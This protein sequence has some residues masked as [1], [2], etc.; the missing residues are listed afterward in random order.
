MEADF[1]LCLF[2]YPVW[3]AACLAGRSVYCQGRTRPDIGEQRARSFRNKTGKRESHS[4]GI[5]FY[6]FTFFWPVSIWVF[7]YWVSLLGVISVPHLFLEHWFCPLNTHTRLACSLAPCTAGL[8]YT[9]GQIAWTL[10]VFV[11]PLKRGFILPV[12]SVAGGLWEE[13]GTVI[14]YLTVRIGKLKISTTQSEP[15]STRGK[16]L[17]FF[18]LANIWAHTVRTR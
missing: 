15:E 11:S 3:F 17:I 10:Q 18:R 13:L 4:A 1:I 5:P 6:R 7:V 14:N 8:L 9:A 2:V 16:S 12:I